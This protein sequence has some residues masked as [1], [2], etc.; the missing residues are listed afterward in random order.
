[1]IIGRLTISSGA[2]RWFTIT[3]PWMTSGEQ[4]TS[5]STTVS[6]EEGASDEGSPT[7]TVTD[8]EIDNTNQQTRFLAGGGIDGTTYTVH[9][10]ILTSLGQTSDDCV[11]YEIDDGGC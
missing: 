9:T 2:R 11:V 3:Y 7:F 8:T 5:F 10:S 1:M 4:I 6:T